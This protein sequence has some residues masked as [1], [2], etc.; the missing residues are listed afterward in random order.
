[1]DES[2]RSVLDYIMLRNIVALMAGNEAE[3]EC[4]GSA[5]GG[6]KEDRRAIAL[7][8]DTE[9]PTFES[10]KEE[11]RLRRAARALV[12]RHRDKIER[13]AA[14]LLAREV[15]SAGEVDVI[16]DLDRNTPV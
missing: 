6:D 7:I 4:L 15:L 13:V 14:A 12:R 1:L 2:G 16:C 3:V 5:N 11:P 10:E 9:F 8:I